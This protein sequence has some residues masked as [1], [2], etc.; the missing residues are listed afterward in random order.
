[1]AHVEFGACPDSEAAL[2]FEE[3]PHRQIIQTVRAVE[4]NLQP[5]WF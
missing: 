5:D 4:D 1:M 2:A 3:L